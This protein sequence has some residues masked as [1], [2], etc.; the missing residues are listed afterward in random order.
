LL[1]I[2]VSFKSSFAPVLAQTARA[3]G[4]ALADA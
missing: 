4:R 3:S 2:P 1:S